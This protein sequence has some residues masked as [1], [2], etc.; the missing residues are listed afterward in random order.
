MAEFLS[1]IL[2]FCLGWDS[3]EFHQEYLQYVN[4][5]FQFTGSSLETYLLRNLLFRKTFNEIGQQIRE[6]IKLINYYIIFF[7]NA[8]LD[9]IRKQRTFKYYDF[10]LDFISTSTRFIA[11]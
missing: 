2:L 6:Y 5:K 3:D 7:L 8:N 1:K 9:G 11:P 10:Y 4:E